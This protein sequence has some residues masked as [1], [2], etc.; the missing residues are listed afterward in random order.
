MRIAV[1]GDTMTD[2]DI[3]CEVVKYYDEAPVLRELSRIE[4]PGGASNVAEMCRALG[5]EVLLLGP[6]DPD[7]TQTIKRR[8][9]VNG[10]L[11]ARHDTETLAPFVWTIHQRQSLNQFSPD[12]IIIADHGKGFITRDLM[13]A[14]PI[15]PTFIDPIALT[16]VI[17]GDQVTWIGGESEIPA[18]ARGHKIVKHGPE[19]LSAWTES[20]LSYRLR[21]ECQ[22]CI[23]D[24][25]AGDQFIAALAVS[26]CKG[27]DWAESI[28]RA[29]IAAGEQCRRQGIK[30][31]TS[32][33]VSTPPEANV[34]RA[35]FA[36]ALP[37]DQ[38]TGTLPE[39]SDA[40]KKKT[41]TQK[42][43]DG[44]TG[45]IKSVLCI[46]RATDD[47]I[48]KR[49]EICSKCEHYKHWMCGLCGCVV[50][51]KIKVA[52]EECPIKKWPKESVNDK[53]ME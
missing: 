1:L 35:K 40:P 24:I 30:P 22:D 12:A 5:A 33:Q 27:L 34:I 17:D 38:T 18:T 45:S 2:V 46:D 11:V 3:E 21:S 31:I 49:W 10:K 7:R 53:D 9:L 52:S 50:S 15:L 8:F 37:T 43:R 51:Q 13:A 23:D 29:N 19:G 47:T 28:K 32:E 14:L 6:C 26:R 42:I 39:D 4:R 44:V 20:G 36:T 25:G 16:P 48:S 41:I